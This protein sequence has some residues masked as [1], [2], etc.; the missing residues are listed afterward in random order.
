MHPLASR[1]FVT[2]GPSRKEETLLLPSHIAIIMDGNG[3]WARER[4]KPRLSGHRAGAEVA[5][6]ISIAARD[7][8]I[9]Y[10]TLYAFSTENWKRPPAEVQGIFRILEDYLHRE[11][12]ALA[13]YGIRMRCIG[14]RAA[15]PASLVRVVD[16]SEHL[17]FSGPRLTVN[18]ALNY[19]GRWDI[20]QAARSI[21]TDAAEGRLAP[22]DVDEDLIAARLSTAGQ[23][24]PD[25]LIRTGGENRI[26]N[27]LLWQ[28]A[29]SEVYVTP[30]L[31]PDFTPNDL[32]SA[33]RA[34]EARDRRYGG[35]NGQGGLP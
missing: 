29:Y 26:S 17:T 8:G 16:E 33:V 22:S 4:G 35:L 27:F 13:G 30:T 20:V 15:L 25:L 18:L 9:A 31:W 34:Y 1:G 7:M 5:K 10:L 19:G 2:Y 14:D 3:R 23:P 21:A 28:L 32:S 6:R 24:D 11:M 12:E